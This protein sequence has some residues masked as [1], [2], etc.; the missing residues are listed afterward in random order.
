M[1]TGFRRSAVRCRQIER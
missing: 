1:K